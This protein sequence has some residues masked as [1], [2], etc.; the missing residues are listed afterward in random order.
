MA[1][2]MVWFRPGYSLRPW[3]T[4]ECTG[5]ECTGEGC[6]AALADRP[7]VAPRLKAR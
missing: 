7:V 1:Y 6:G 2:M 5:E 4:E 3:E